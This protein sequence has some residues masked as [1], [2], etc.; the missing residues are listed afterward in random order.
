MAVRSHLFLARS[1]VSGRA[2]ASSTATGF[3]PLSSWRSLTSSAVGSVASLSVLAAFH[4]ALMC[5]EYD[6]SSADCGVDVADEPVLAA[7]GHDAGHHLRA[8]AG[9]RPRLHPS[10]PKHHR[11]VDPARPHPDPGDGNPQP[12][13][14]SRWQHRHQPSGRNLGPEHSSDSLAR[15]PTRKG[16][17]PLPKSQQASVS[18]RTAPSTPQPS[19]A[20][21]IILPGSR[22]RGGSGSR[23]RPVAA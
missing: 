1:L 6:P 4:I 8:V 5:S 15:P 21:R 18:D 13:A 22:W 14:Q 16:S 7:D 10:A 19:K 11:V 9:F 17:G 23:S 12:D 20:A 2:I 3:L